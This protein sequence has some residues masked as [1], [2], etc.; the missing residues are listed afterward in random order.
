M[1]LSLVDV[2]IN[3]ATVTAVHEFHSIKGYGVDFYVEA[4]SNNGAVFL[5]IIVYD[6]E[7]RNYCR[8]IHE[9]DHVKVT[10]NMTV[11]PYAKKDGTTGCSFVVER[12]IMFRKI[13]GWNSEQQLL[14]RGNQVETP[15]LEDIV[16]AE[17]A[18][19]ATAI[20]ADNKSDNNDKLQ[21]K[22]NE[23]ETALQNPHTVTAEQQNKELNEQISRI[24]TKR[25]PPLRFSSEYRQP[26]PEDED[27]LPF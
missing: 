19:T 12:P 24:E 4:R 7:A 27:D 9:G 6:N 15:S 2:N 14:Q 22:T 13:V 11:K 17:N 8:Y 20:S 3:E 21:H 1:S 26:T 25:Y 5:Q 23:T 10:G 18:I 16:A